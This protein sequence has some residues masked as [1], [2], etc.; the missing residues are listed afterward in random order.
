MTQRAGQ[1]GVALIEAIV[2]IV[3]VS[4][5]AVTILSQIS[6]ANV[7]SGRSITQSESAAIAAAYLTEIVARPF[8]DP[9]GA[10]GETQRRLFDDVDDYNGLND[11]GAR[12]ANGNLI[13]GANRFAV[14]VAV[15]ASAALPGVPAAD[16]RLVT[17]T[18]TDPVAAVTTATGLR[19]RP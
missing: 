4:I 16:T 13:P 19:L 12:D 11:N 18:V 14:R 8:D 2:A 10:D 17:V 3:I 1:A 5:A 9:D 15:S 6:Q 7:Q